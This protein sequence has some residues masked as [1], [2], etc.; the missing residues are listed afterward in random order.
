MIEAATVIRKRDHEY[1]PVTTADPNAAKPTEEEKPE[2]KKEADSKPEEKTESA[3]E[4][5]EE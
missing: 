4:N 2:E 3:E 5:K 1:K